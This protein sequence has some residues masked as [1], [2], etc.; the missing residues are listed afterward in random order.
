MEKEPRALGFGGPTTATVHIVDELDSWHPTCLDVLRPE[1]VWESFM[2]ENLAMGKKVFDDLA[3]GMAEAKRR[4]R[5]LDSRFP[6]DTLDAFLYS[7]RYSLREMSC[8][9]MTTH[10]ASRQFFIEATDSAKIEQWPTRKEAHY[11]AH[12]KKARTRKKY[13]NRIRRKRKRHAFKRFQSILKE[14]AAVHK[15]GCM[16][17]AAADAQFVIRMDEVTPDFLSLL[18]EPSGWRNGLADSINDCTQVRAHL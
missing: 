13:H 15:Q 17:R 1:K 18:A 11:I 2:R 12:A 8:V 7:L 16:M 9:A 14:A 5:S 6:R 10:E 4:S 3:A